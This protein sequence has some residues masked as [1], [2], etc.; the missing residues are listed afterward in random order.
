MIGILTGKSKC[1][2]M[3]SPG[4]IQE[5][6]IGRRSKPCPPMTRIGN[7]QDHHRIHQLVAIHRAIQ[8]PAAPTTSLS[9][10]ILQQTLKAI[11]LA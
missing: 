3:K 11:G 6:H 7:L 10:S 8:Q 2:H 1:G 4:I 9:S 5:I